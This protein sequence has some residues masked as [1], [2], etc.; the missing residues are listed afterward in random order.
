MKIPVADRMVEVETDG[1]DD[2]Y[3]LWPI[4]SKQA[5]K[6]EAPQGSA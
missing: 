1:L 6:E 3:P 4:L 5:A 2:D